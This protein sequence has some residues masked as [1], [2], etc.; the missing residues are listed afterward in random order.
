MTSPR[1][2]RLVQWFG[3]NSENAEEP[4]RL[5]DGCR[6]VGIPFAGGMAE[7]PYIAAK[8]VLV[9]DL[10][11]HVINLC[12]VISKEEGRS[13]IIS[14]ADAMPYHPDVLASAQKKAA[15]W[16]WQDGPSAEAALWYFV[17]VW[18]GRGGKAGT[19]G[20]FAGQ[21][22]I[23]W[24]ANGG[25]SNRRY[26]TAIEALDEWGEAFRRCEFVCMDAFDFLG[27]F[28]DHAGHGLYVD[29]PWPDAGEEYTHRFGEA[30]QRRLAARLG[31]FE[32]AKIVVRYGEH[33]L[34]REIYD[35]WRWFPLESRTQANER[36]PEY[37][38]CNWSRGDDATPPGCA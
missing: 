26:R 30:D 16:D 12:Q 27:K 3:A 29:S 6:F 37:L 2:S 13:W 21:L 8:Q 28:R 20:E 1:T 38:I 7:V 15:E 9:N 24:N 34:I 18:M 33:P 4:G 11:R 5:L 35:G 23:R 19:P 10:H 14:E 32:R 25:G 36:K 17:A 31:Q 22:P